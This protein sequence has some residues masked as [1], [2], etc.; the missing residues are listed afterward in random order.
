[1]HAVFMNLVKS[2]LLTVKCELLLQQYTL[3]CVR[4]G[5]TLAAASFD[6]AS[7]GTAWVMD[8]VGRLWFTT[9]VSVAQ[10]EGS[11]LWWQVCSNLVGFSVDFVPQ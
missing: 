3:L 7:D 9:D 6:L 11:G 1:M 2:E 10:P 5:P 4:S 8:V